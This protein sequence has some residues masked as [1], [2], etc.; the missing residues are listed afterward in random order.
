MAM[1]V[2]RFK[3]EVSTKWRAYLFW[4]G[5]A[6]LCEVLFLLGLKKWLVVIT[7]SPGNLSPFFKGGIFLGSIL[8]LR[9]LFQLTHE[10][11]LTENLLRESENWRKKILDAWTHTRIPVFRDPWSEQIRAVLAD[12]LSGWEAGQRARMQF[13]L[14]V[15]QLIILLVLMVIFPWQAFAL[16]CMLGVPVIL[17]MKWKVSTLK[18][19]QHQYTESEIQKN[20]TIQQFH[21]RAL[22]LKA[23]LNNEIMESLRHVLRLF[24][25]GKKK[26]RQQSTYLPATIEFLFFWLILLAI[27]GFSQMYPN[28]NQD[29]TVMLSF[30]VYLVVMYRPVREIAKNYPPLL[31]GSEAKTQMV[32]ILQKLGEKTLPNPK[33]KYIT[34]NKINLVQV[35]F[36][37]TTGA[38]LWGTLNASLELGT[39]ICLWGANG[40]G[41]ST[42]LKL[43]AGLEEPYQGWMELPKHWK[44]T[45]PWSYLPENAVLIPGLKNHTEIEDIYR[46]ELR[47]ILELDWAASFLESSGYKWQ[48][49]Q[50]KFSSGQLQRLALY[51]ALTFPSEG[52]LLDEP[53]K[54]LPSNQE[55]EILEKSIGWWKR[56]HPQGTVVF[57]THHT[58]HKKLANFVMNFSK[59]YSPQFDH[60]VV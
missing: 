56:R 8:G 37:Y 26:W 41:K 19:F 31:S 59:D 38:S 33:W 21:G 50:K 9:L 57:S 13:I 1:T 47:E 30:L 2:N 18:K 20:R 32:N 12:H 49:D 6:A 54:G 11:I 3:I 51:Q 15:I 7:S 58:E 39:C 27:L 4:G 28:L 42:F 52:I 34:K 35:E 10:K 46:K 5:A 45:S 44:D 36:H 53:T 48:E 23:H 17:L 14:G 60:Y 24:E 22:W 40:T 16:V 25:E 29:K 43:L 55:M